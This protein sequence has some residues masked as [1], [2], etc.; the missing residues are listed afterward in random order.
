M[1]FSIDYLQVFQKKRAIIARFSIF[2]I[3]EEITEA[4][5]TAEQ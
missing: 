5:P 4:Q 2:Y 1:K 3:L